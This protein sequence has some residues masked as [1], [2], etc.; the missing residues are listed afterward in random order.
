MAIRICEWTKTHCIMYFQCVNCAVCESYLNKAGLKNEKT[1]TSNWNWEV[2]AD[3]LDTLSVCS[4]TLEK[5]FTSL[6]PVG[7]ST[8]QE[9]LMPATEEYREESGDGRYVASRIG[10]EALFKWTRFTVEMSL[11][12]EAAT[13]LSYGLRLPQNVKLQGA[14]ETNQEHS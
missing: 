9:R 2:W 3:V 7:P 10:T 1:R 14:S 8:R 11:P 5:P 6:S 13:S 12:W 4:V